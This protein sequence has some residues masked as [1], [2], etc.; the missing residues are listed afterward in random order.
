VK[1]PSDVSNVAVGFGMAAPTMKREG[2]QKPG[3]TALQAQS[4]LIRLRNVT[5]SEFAS[6]A[7]DT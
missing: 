3:A 5:C 4:A 2:W 6:I 7:G 1:D